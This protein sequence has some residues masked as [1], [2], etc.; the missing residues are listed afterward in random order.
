LAGVDIVGADMSCWPD[1]PGLLAQRAQ[2]LMMTVGSGELSAVSQGDVGS[3]WALD[4]QG[5]RDVR[6]RRESVL[7]GEMRLKE[8]EIGGAS[9][10]V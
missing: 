9:E 2:R 6:T 3:D 10:R 8:Q 7:T 4:K 1:G 5:E